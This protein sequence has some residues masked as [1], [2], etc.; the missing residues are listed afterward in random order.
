MLGRRH[1][2]RPKLR[3]CDFRWAAGVYVLERSGHP[4][5][6]G[7]AR[8]EQGLGARL[9]HHTED[10]TKKWTH[11]SWFSFDDVRHD[12]PR[13]T[14][15]PFPPGWAAVH[16]RHVLD[17]TPMRSVV[18]ELEALLVNLMIDKSLVNI[19]RPRFPGAEA[20]TQV[21]SQNYTQPGI[22]HRVDR[23]WFGDARCFAI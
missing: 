11:F 23:S 22:C 14:Y 4:T 8:S 18:G 12:E 3:V 1:A 10:E 2:R 21:V 6:T 13:S 17:R 15:P 19:Q 20:W 9:L 7:L 16:P 5:Y